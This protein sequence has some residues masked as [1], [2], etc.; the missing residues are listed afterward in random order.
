MLVASSSNSGSFLGFDNN[1]VI[2]ESFLLCTRMVRRESQCDG[3]KIAQVTFVKCYT[4]CLARN[5]ALP[6]QCIKKIYRNG[7]DP[8]D[9]PQLVA[10][11]TL[12][13][14]FIPVTRFDA[15]QHYNILS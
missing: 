4:T 2:C 6:A 11:K 5:V 13:D 3:R 14:M 9:R 7:V 8:S 1:K 12:Q 10:T 15:Q